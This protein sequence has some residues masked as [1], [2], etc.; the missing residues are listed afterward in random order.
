MTILKENVLIKGKRV[1]ENLVLKSYIIFMQL[2]GH[3]PPSRN[4]KE[5]SGYSRLPQALPPVVFFSL[6]EKLPKYRQIL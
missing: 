2:A 6:F 5:R 1:S 3:D 4:I